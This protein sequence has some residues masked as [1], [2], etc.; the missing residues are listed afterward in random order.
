V[1]C[2]CKVNKREKAIKHLILFLEKTLKKRKRFG[3]ERHETRENLRMRK[4]MLELQSALRATE[5]K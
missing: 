5:F 2:K 1:G 3:G 4:I